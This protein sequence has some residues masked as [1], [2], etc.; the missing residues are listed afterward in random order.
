MIDVDHVQLRDPEYKIKESFIEAVIQAE[1]DRLKKQEF[2]AEM[3]NIIDQAAR[4]R[5]DGSVMYEI[6][7]S[8]FLKMLHEAQ[9][10]VD[11][12]KDMDVPDMRQFLIALENRAKSLG[13]LK[14]QT[15]WT[16]IHCKLIFE[17]IFIVIKVA[18]N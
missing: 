11:F 2:R 5:N 1:K 18:V 13:I 17:S 8:E 7:D 10:I 4:P 9:L 15:F 6:T 14:W 3:I 12:V 16:E